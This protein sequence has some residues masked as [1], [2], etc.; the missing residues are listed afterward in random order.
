MANTSN[1]KIIP[2]FPDYIISKYSGRVF[3]MKSMLFLKSRLRGSKEGY[4]GVTL[5]QK[6]KTYD[7]HIHRLVLETFIGPCP[8]DMEACHNN[9][10][11][12]DNQLNNLRWDTRSNN[13]RDA[14]K[15]GTHPG[16]KHGEEN[17]FSKLTEFDVKQII[18]LY[19][20][21]DFTQQEIATAYKITQQTVS[22]ILCKRSWKYIWG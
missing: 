11:R 10:N 18:K 15:H 6:G 20:T 9:G 14:V 3:S 16:L 12:F 5:C 4:I 2:K 1:W 21:G 22:D 13:H 7:K 17:A 19:K 8:K